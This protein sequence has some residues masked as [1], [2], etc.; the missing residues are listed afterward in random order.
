M[1]YLQL[2]WGIIKKDTGEI[3]HANSRLFPAATADNNVVRRSS[4]QGRRFKS[5]GKKH[6]SVRLKDLFEY[7]DLLTDFF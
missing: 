7:Y 4:R 3:I 6:R 5:I 1:V 2:E